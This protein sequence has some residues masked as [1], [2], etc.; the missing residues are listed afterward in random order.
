MRTFR[1]EPLTLPS[2]ELLVGDFDS[3]TIDGIPQLRDIL[4]QTKSLL[5]EPAGNNCRDWERKTRQMEPSL[6]IRDKLNELYSPQLV[7]NAFLKLIEIVAWAKIVTPGKSIKMFDNASAPGAFIMAMRYWT[8]MIEK[9]KFDWTASSLVPK[10]GNFALRDTYG[11]AK[12]Y[13]KK[14]A[15]YGTSFDGN[16]WDTEYIRY[17]RKTFGGSY[18]LYTS[19]LGKKAPLGKYNF[20]E[21]VNARGNLG[22]ILIG[23]L[24][25]KYGGTLVTKQF[26]HM[27]SF[28]ISLIAIIAGCF[29][30]VHIV[31]PIASKPDNSEEYIVAKGFRGAPEH[32]IE[33]MFAALDNTK[34]WEAPDF[35][36]EALEFAHPLL[37]GHCLTSEFIDSI[38]SATAT[39]VESQCDKLHANLAEYRRMC[40]HRERMPSDEFLN[41]HV[42]CWIDKWFEIAA[43]K[44]MPKELYMNV[45]LTQH[46]QPG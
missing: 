46:K 29:D 44:K 28:T 19:D 37:P 9:C 26:T 24:V 10:D 3:W 42:T 2:K 17:L 7:T 40:E 18:D 25:L 38:L 34:V 14:F 13:R 36:I 27:S 33:K 15:T 41:A 45:R 30:E 31:K 16:T 1:I 8:T 6:A 35:D 23:L 39:L 12:L 4:N 21:A 20:Q 22:Q 5:D 11:L 32:V 43:F